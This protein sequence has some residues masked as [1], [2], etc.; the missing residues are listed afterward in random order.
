MHFQ[1][2]L[3]VPLSGP[4]H[5]FYI[6]KYLWLIRLV[7]VCCFCF[8][9]LQFS[10]ALFINVCCNQTQIVFVSF[11]ILLISLPSRRF[12]FLLSIFWRFQL[13]LFCFLIIWLK[14]KRKKKEKQQANW[15]LISARTSAYGV[16]SALWGLFSNNV[17]LVLN[18]RKEFS[19][20]LHSALIIHSH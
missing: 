8:F 16:S 1:V 17:H 3:Y 4:K 10:F 20:F 15:M 5:Y 19:S 11:S 7:A 18:I 9:R 12:F 13:I 2:T 6:H 14:T